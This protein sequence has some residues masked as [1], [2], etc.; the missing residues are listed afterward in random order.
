MRRRHAVAD[1]QDD[2]LRLARARAVNRPGEFTSGRAVAHQHP[3]GAGLREHDVVQ[4]QRGLLLAVLALDER[5]GL[6][7]GFGVIFPVQRHF[8]GGGIGEPGKLDFEIEPGASEN[9]CA[10]DRINRLRLGRQR[11]KQNENCN[12]RSGKSR[13]AK[14]LHRSM[15]RT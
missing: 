14:V 12:C 7:K 10:I 8:D 4:N 6:A 2:I 15:E 1:Q 3:V 13:H 5:R 11:E 9:F